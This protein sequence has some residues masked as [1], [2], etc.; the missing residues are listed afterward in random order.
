MP[1]SKNIQFAKDL[2]AGDRIRFREQEVTLVE[3]RRFEDDKSVYL[4]FKDGP[5]TEFPNHNR[6]FVSRFEAFEVLP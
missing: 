6:A 2:K 1:T 5:E 4:K 3:T